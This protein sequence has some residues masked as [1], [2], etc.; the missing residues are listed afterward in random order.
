MAFKRAL[1]GLGPTAGTLGATSP[2]PYLPNAH[3]STHISMMA[4]PILAVVF[5]LCLCLIH[6]PEP[7]SSGLSVVGI[8]LEHLISM[9]TSVP[10]LQF[11]PALNQ[12]SYGTIVHYKCAP[13]VCIKNEENGWMHSLLKANRDKHYLSRSRLKRFALNNFCL[14]F[15]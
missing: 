14:V 10:P 5:A 9:N 8:S 1:N 12:I 4:G 7:A 11:S 6:V 3:S 2:F 13:I 15:S